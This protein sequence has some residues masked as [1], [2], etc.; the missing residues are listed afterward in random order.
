MDFAIR[1]ATEADLEALVQCHKS[2]MD[3]HINVDKRFTLRPGVE[4]NWKEQ[5]M[6]SLNNPGTLIL[7]AEVDSKIAG[8]AYIMIKEGA[9]D[10]GSEK[11]GYLCDVFVEPDCRR[12]GITREFL[13]T[14][15]KWLQERGINTVEVNWSVHCVEAQNTWRALGFIPLSISGRMDF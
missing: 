5:I 6:V 9:M 10:F 14:S 8:C 7:V 1:N 15:C 12:Q 11:I 4:E 2:F 13:A 3:H